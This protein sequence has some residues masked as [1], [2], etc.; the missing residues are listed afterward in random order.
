MAKVVILWP[1]CPRFWRAGLL[2]GHATYDFAHIRANMSVVM[3]YV[4]QQIYEMHNDTYL[5]TFLCAADRYLDAT[6]C[7]Q[8]L[9][10]IIT[11]TICVFTSILYLHGC[12]IPV[13][14]HKA[15]AEVSRLGNV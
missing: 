2:E 13:V 8:K 11:H 4:Y 15:V 1:W 14:P 6:R 9:L 12:T 10:H 3:Y 7:E 5:C